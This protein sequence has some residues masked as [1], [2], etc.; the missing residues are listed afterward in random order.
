[1]LLRKQNKH[2]QIKYMSET[3]SHDLKVI[4]LQIKGS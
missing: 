3:W 1:M 4:Q 2:Y